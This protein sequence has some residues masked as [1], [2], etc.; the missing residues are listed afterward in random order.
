MDSDQGQSTSLQPHQDASHLA[1]KESGKE[2]LTNEIVSQQSS[3][4]LPDT[5][6]DSWSLKMSPACSPAPTPQKIQECT[7]TTWE[8]NSENQDTLSKGL[9]FQVVTLQ[10]PSIEKDCYW[11]PSPTALST[12][13]SRPPGRSKLE[14]FL[15]QKQLINKEEVVNPEFLESA[16]NLPIGWTDPQDERSAWEF[17]EEM[18]PYAHAEQPSETHLTLESPALPSEE[19]CTYNQSRSESTPEKFLEEKKKRNRKGC[20]YKYLENKKLKDGTIASYPRVKG[21][22]I[23]S[24]PVGAIPMIQSM[25]KLG[26]PLEEIISFIRRSK[27]KK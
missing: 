21:R 5:S 27:A 9:S 14:N 25:Q 6:P 19:S 15:K 10:L 16:Y 7:V 23:G 20:L 26:V 2:Q 17:L 12:R 4:S 8:A 11:L 1:F 22:S 13:K 3:K 24:V 18:E